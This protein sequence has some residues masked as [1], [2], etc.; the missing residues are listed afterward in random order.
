M[1]DI[2]VIDDWPINR[3]F[4]ATLLRYAGHTVREAAEG[5]EALERMREAR[6]DIV[7]TDI[8]MPGMDGVEFAKRV[9]ANHEFAGI[10]VIFYT[11][12]YRLSEAR[13]LASTCGVMT[14]LPK[15]SDPQH[16]LD[17]IHGEL[18]LPLVTFAASGSGEKG[19]PPPVQPPTREI[20]VRHLR[21]LGD[22][23]AELR[24]SVGELGAPFNGEAQRWNNVMTRVDAS[25]LSAQALAMRLAT[26]IELGADLAGRSRPT[27][28][29]EVFC[30]AACNVL[31]AKLAVACI[32]D[33]EGKVQELVANGLSA[34]QTATLRRQLGHVA[35]L[36]GELLRDG[37][38][39]NLE[40]EVDP[41]GIG[42]PASH[43]PIAN[44]L[45]ARVA[46]RS[47]TYGWFYVASRVETSDG[48]G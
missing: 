2:L 4:L 10:P 44:L 16:V 9:T 39:R 37:H 30:R 43:P 20:Q 28:L 33:E 47:R 5:A 21:E 23:Q 36:L 40:N 25:F 27:E 8:L 17:A 12:T 38:V 3:D 14:I 24:T 11:A 19:G 42:L 26:V 46:T 31:S 7:I 45:A 34:E 35:G 48:R 18:G 15:P 32:L 6:P 29:L 41:V 22:L 1:A 13:E